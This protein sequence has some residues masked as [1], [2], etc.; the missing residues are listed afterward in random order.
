MSSKGLTTRSKRASA[1]DPPPSQPAR[2]APRIKSR[3]KAA[4]SHTDEKSALL[5]RYH[6]EYDKGEALTNELVAAGSFAQFK[7][8]GKAL[9]SC[10]VSA[11]LILCTLLD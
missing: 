10:L 6:S 1:P 2:P 8:A 4:P 11:F 5:D 9:D 3:P 7:I